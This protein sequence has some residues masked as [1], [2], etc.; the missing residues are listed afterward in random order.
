M[1]ASQ[2]ILWCGTGQPAP[3]M[4]LG[5]LGMF[6][7]GLSSSDCA[8]QCLTTIPYGNAIQRNPDL[9]I[10]H[11]GTLGVGTVNLELPHVEGKIHF[12]LIEFGLYV[13]DRII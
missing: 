3:L 4:S 11:M 13:T 9:L 10:K 8:Q 12:I 7:T 2:R 6:L 5:Y 1:V